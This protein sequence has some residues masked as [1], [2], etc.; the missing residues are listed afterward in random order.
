MADRTSMPTWVRGL[1]YAGFG[2]AV[3]GYFVGALSS[4]LLDPERRSQTALLL[5]H[6]QAGAADEV[7]E[8]ALAQ[9]YWKENADVAAD[10]VFGRMGA[11][12]IWVP[13][14]ILSGMEKGRGDAGRRSRD[15][16]SHK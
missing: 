10:A 11:M 15:R 12:G 3:A 4:P 1:A 13:G 16:R 6:A 14:N 7:R 5:R 2:L 9:R 8:R